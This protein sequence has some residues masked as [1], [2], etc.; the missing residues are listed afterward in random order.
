MYDDSILFVTILNRK[1][2]HIPLRFI[3]RLEIVLSFP[4]NK[5]QCVIEKLSKKNVKCFGSEFRV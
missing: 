1:H 2:E 5:G 4:L 3:E